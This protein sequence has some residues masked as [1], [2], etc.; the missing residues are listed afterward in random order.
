MTTNHTPRILDPARALLDAKKLIEM[1][2]PLLDEIVNYS[3]G[4]FRRSISAQEP[5]DAD[6]AP[7]VLYLQQM[8][9]TDG[10][11][12]LISQSCCEPTVPLIRSSFEVFISLKY[13]LTEDCKNRSL[14]WLYFDDRRKTEIYQQLDRESEKGQELSQAYGRELPDLKIPGVSEQQLNYIRK[15][16][17]NEF[18]EPIK[19]EYERTRRDRKIK[20]PKWYTL[21]G[22]PKNI[23]ALAKS[24]SSEYM[25]ITLYRNWSAFAHG[26]DSSR[27]IE[28]LPDGRVVGHQLR[29][30]DNLLTYSFYAGSFLWMATDLMMNRLGPGE[31]SHATWSDEKR[32]KLTDLLNVR[33]TVQRRS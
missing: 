2:G 29:R 22:G 25:Y 28:T 17:H 24:L 20:K 3:V 6:L 15:R 13:L 19:Q 12:V 32:N 27:Y 14:S 5:T 26:V 33:I 8:E 23:Q 16:S 4:V 31:L 10:I 18:F 21:F 1:A 7:L 30:A 11:R 9:L